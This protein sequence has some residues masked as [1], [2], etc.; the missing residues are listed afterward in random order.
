MLRRSEGFTL[1]EVMI[2]LAV[3]ATALMMT[4]TLRNRDILYHDEARHIVQAT[5][6]AQERVTEMEV[7]EKF[8]DLGVSSD[9]FEA[10]NDEYE[11]LQTVTPTLFDVAREVHVK[12]SW[13]SKKNEAVELTTYVLSLK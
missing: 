1:L 11:W 6:L 12:V 9:R 10:P 3:V 13:G 2:A 4:G 7:K 8:P 5:L